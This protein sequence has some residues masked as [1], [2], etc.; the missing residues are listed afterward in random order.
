MFSLMPPW[1]VLAL[2]YY[3]FGRLFNFWTKLWFL[4]KTWVQMDNN[5]WF[6][7]K[8]YI[9]ELN[10][11]WKFRFL[12]KN[13]DYESNYWWKFRFSSKII[14]K[15]LWFCSKFLLLC[16]INDKNFDFWVKIIDQNL[17]F[18][19]KITIFESTYCSTLWFFF[20]KISILE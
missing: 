12:R 19:T 8:I 10:Y 17:W 2:V 11:W 5:L 20:I 18:L 3:E 13:F 15:N 14:H 16:Q 4:T 6:L 7:I 9:L 1:Q